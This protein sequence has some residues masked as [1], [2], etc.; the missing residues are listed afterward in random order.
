LDIPITIAWDKDISLYHIRQ[1]CSRFFGIRQTFYIYDKWDLLA[2]KK[3]SPADAP[4]K[5][6]NF[7][8]KHRIEYTEKEHNLY[9]K[10]KQER[11]NI[12]NG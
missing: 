3:D 7:L 4:N 11:E 8:F 5:I 1:T 12:K 10:E 9:L 6:Y 2:G